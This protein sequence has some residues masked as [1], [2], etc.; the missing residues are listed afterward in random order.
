MQCGDFDGMLDGILEFVVKK[1]PPKDY[2]SL[3][4]K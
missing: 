4:E 2:Y 3:Q 1:N